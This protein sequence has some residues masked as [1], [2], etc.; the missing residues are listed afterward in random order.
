MGKD[1]YNN[2]WYVERDF[3]DEIKENYGFFDNLL[4]DF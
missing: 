3:V 2:K 4:E 1:Q